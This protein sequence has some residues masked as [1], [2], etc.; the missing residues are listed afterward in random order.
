MAASKVPKRTNG[1]SL[2][3]KIKIYFPFYIMLLPV[4]TLLF[5]FEYMPMRHVDIAFYRFTTFGRQEFIGLAQFRRLF[6]SP[7]FFEVMRNTMEIS[8]TNLFLMMFFAIVLALLLNEVRFKTFKRFTQT[9]LY[10][11]FFLSWVVVG[12]IF[13]MIL[14][15][16]TGFTGPIFDFF[17]MPHRQPLTMPDLWRPLFYAINL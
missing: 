7:R 8:L 13:T 15:P 1:A 11:P 14:S 9:V 12:S 10:L 6:N 4:V 17:G 16:L 5:L 2:W 3:R